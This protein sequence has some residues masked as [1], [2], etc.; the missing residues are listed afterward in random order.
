MNEIDSLD[1]E[2]Q[3][4]FRDYVIQHPELAEEYAALK[5]ELAQRYTTDREAY[6]DGKAPFIERVLGMARS[7]VALSGDRRT[8]NGG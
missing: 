6:T 2:N 3:V 7:A 8:G 5:A 4:L 1:W